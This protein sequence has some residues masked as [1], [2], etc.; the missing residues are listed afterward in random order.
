FLKTRHMCFD[1]AHG[2]APL[3]TLLKKIRSKTSNARNEIG[4]ISFALFIDALFEMSRYYLVHYLVHPILGGERALDGDE[5]LV[6]SKNHRG[7]DFHVNVRRASLDG[8]FQNLLKQFHA[9]KRSN[10][11]ATCQSPNF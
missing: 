2:Q 7:G 6:D 1:M 4:K 8:G 11:L 5:L 3:A 10:S 9:A